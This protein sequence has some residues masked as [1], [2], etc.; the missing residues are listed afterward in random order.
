MQKIDFHRLW[1]AFD[2][3][4]LLPFLARLPRWLGRRLATWR[5]LLY[6]RLGRDWRQ[7]CLGDQAL[8]SR[9]L[10]ALRELLPTANSSELRCAVRQRYAAQSLEELEAC[11]LA[12]PDLRQWPVEW[13]GLDSVLDAIQV[14][15]S[16]VLVTAH[17]SS[18]V[19]GVVLLE[20]L[21]IPVL[22]MTSNITEDPRV[23]PSIQ[24]FYRHRKKNGDRYLN[25]GEVLDRQG[26][27]RR[28]VQRLKKGGAVVIFGEL[29]P[30][31]HE[32]PLIVSFLGAKRKLAAGPQRLADLAKVPLFSFV[33]EY[34]PTGY[35]MSFSTPDGDPYSHIDEAIRRNPARWW[36]ADLLPLLPRVPETADE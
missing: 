22:A 26:N 4:H 13:V 20:R 12:R 6:A 5:G 11:Q 18:C 21:G 36:A 34:T 2:Y 29:P 14:H 31:P 3:D 35:R 32:E 30:D 28:F 10:E 27:T 33:C 15:G 19:L 16:I 23:H 1:T 8:E 25:G 7:F 17:Y 24:R 9:T